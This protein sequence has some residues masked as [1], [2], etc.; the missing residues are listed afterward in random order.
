MQYVEV[1]HDTLEANASVDGETDWVFGM[2]DQ[3]VAD[4]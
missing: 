1:T 2:S 4:T 3:F